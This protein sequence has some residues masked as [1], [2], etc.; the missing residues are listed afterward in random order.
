[1][2]RSNGQLEVSNW[3]VDRDE[4]WRPANLT[5]V[6]I[7][8]QGVNGVLIQDPRTGSVYS[9]KLGQ[10]FILETRPETVYVLAAANDNTDGIDYQ[11]YV[12]TP[13]WA[14]AHGHRR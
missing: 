12:A 9:L 6:A 2:M 10:A 11:V 4:S 8:L 1:M 5:D 7:Q 13:E 3:I 14:Y